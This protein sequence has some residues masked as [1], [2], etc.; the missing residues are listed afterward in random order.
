MEMAYSIS[1]IRAAA[2][3]GRRPD[4]YSVLGIISCFGSVGGTYPRCGELA[5]GLL[6]LPAGGEVVSLY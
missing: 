2:G 3:V 4:L 5:G 6:R 1:T